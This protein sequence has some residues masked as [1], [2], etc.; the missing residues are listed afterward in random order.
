M[1]VSQAAADRIKFRSHYDTQEGVNP[2]P[3][4]A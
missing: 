1:F 2:E 4:H 3:E